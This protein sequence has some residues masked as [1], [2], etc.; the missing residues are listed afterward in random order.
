MYMT[1][2]SLLLLLL[3]VCSKC[4]VALLAPYAEWVLLQLCALGR[5]LA[6]A[7]KTCTTYM[8]CKC[9]CVVPVVLRNS[10]TQQQ[11]KV[12]VS[13]YAFECRRHVR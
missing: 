3:C 10:S 7:C 2:C 6:W 1:C 13:R 9:C 8:L 12:L 4:R 5:M 11:Q